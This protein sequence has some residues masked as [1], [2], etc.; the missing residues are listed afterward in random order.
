MQISGFAGSSLPDSPIAGCPSADCAEGNQASLDGQLP[1]FLGLFALYLSNTATLTGGQDSLGSA[2]SGD[3]SQNVEPNA[4]GTSNPFPSVLNLHPIGSLSAEGTP[5]PSA[6]EQIFQK[7][8]IAAG[9]PPAMTENPSNANSA[10]LDGQVNS[11][12][13]NQMVQSP[14]HATNTPIL[15]GNEHSAEETIDNS[16]QQQSP[17]P[18]G[19]LDPNPRLSVSTE[20]LQI[21][22]NETTGYS[23][24]EKF[25]AA[26]ARSK[27]DSLA[28]D[29][30]SHDTNV[31]SK[32]E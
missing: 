13:L 9:E 28:K 22:S 12:L 32:S 2:V 7:L 30:W 17:G 29:K 15:T 3:T 25:E 19:V 8:L 18:K 4:S 26:L 5:T 23:D 20:A 10:P 6:A 14:D 11:S 16:S 31:E 21:Q 27:T 24:W 1:G